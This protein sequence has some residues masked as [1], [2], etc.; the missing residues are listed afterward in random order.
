LLQILFYAVRPSLDGGRILR[1]LIRAEID[2]VGEE[3]DDRIW[4]TEVGSPWFLARGWGCNGF[5]CMVG[6]ETESVMS[7]DTNNTRS[8][9]HCSP[10]SL[11]YTP[12]NI[13]ES[14]KAKRERLGRPYFTQR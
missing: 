7:A 14:V 3:I 5:V 9:L 1:G 11:D 12:T 2:D 13:R 6:H 8:V 10:A 4:E